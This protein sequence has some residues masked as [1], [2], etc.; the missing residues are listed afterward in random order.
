[1]LRRPLSPLSFLLSLVHAEARGSLGGP[2][3]AA[4]CMT[5]QGADLGCAGWITNRVW[6]ILT[7]SDK[8]TM[9]EKCENARFSYL[10]AK[11]RNSPTEM[12][13]TEVPM[14][15]AASEIPLAFRFIHVAVGRPFVH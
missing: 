5:Q 1:M 3:S 14:P 4:K 9:S 6:R 10:I 12:R 11:Y 8:H 13:N 15:V 7:M 2:G